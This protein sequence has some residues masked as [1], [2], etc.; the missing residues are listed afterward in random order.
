MS[1]AVVF[2][3][4]AAFSDRIVVFDLSKREVLTREIL[5]QAILKLTDASH[6]SECANCPLNA[7]CEVHRNRT[8]LNSELFQDRLYVILQR[9]SLQGYHATLRELQGLIAYLIF[10]N[11]SCVEIN[12]TAGSNRFNIVN[13]VY[14]GKGALFDAIRASI[15]PIAISHPVWDERIL[16]NDIPADSWIS[17]YEV[18]A[19]AIAYDNFDLFMLR[20]REF[21]FFNQNGSEL[22]KILDDDVTHFQEFLSQENG[23]TIKELI[24]KLNTF[25][26]AIKPSNSELQIWSGHRY[27]NEPRK[28]LVSVGTIKKSGLKIGRPSLL[29]SISAGIEMTSNY[30]RLEKKD[31]PNIFLKIDFEMYM[32]LSEAERGVPVLFMES[33][34]VKK[35]WR[36]IEQ[37]Q[38]FKDIGE[39]DSV[40]VALLDIQNKKKISVVIDREENK[41]SSIDIEKAKE[42]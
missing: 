12:R 36:F 31:A 41:Y 3:D 26:G 19:E 4:E 9:V 32:L 40:N 7:S 38:S 25:F 35:V 2:H 13:L 37:L 23:K 34:L 6:Y 1:H 29:K 28:V 17:S 18:P 27:D 15:D 16:L 5:R 22:L 8:L 21:Y 30:I 24:R 20:K 11:R 33:D 42:V 39:D 10:G 14:S